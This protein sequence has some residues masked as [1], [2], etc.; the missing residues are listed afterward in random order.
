MKKLVV[1]KIE[2][3]LDDRWEL[4]RGER[5]YWRVYFFESRDRRIRKK[6]IAARDELDAF[7]RFQKRK[8]LEGHK[9]V[10]EGEHDNI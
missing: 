3:N 1:F 10:L 5:L 2:P 4:V 7:I 6:S 8:Q 9:V